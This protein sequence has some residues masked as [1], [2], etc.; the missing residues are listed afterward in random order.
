MGD[1][2]CVGITMAIDWEDDDR[3]LDERLARRALGYFRPYWRAAALAMAC[4]LVGAALGLV[5]ALVFKELIDYLADP[6]DG[7]L[8]VALLVGG[9]VVAAILGGL[10]GVAQSYLSERISQGII[11]DLRGQVF[12]SLLRQ[13]VGFYT[14]NRGGDVLSRINNDVNGIEDVVADTVLG[15]VRNAVVAASTLALMF[16]FDW[17]LTLVALLV[18]PA[19]ALP[20]RR[21]GHKVYDAQGRVQRK[22]SEM[23]AYL[24][25]VL[26][27]SGA[28]PP[29]VPSSPGSEGRTTSCGSSRSAPPWSGAASRWRWTCCRRSGPAC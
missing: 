23:T 25:E 19:A 22:L 7:F 1:R 14:S 12:D 16:V 6:D 21:A 11:F 10:I 27:I 2:Y 18:I 17:Q 29:S 4:L 9:S 15:L 3:R 8:P 20:M 5:P 26:G 13:S 24:Q 28:M